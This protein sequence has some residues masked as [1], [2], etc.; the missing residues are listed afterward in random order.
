MPRALIGVHGLSVCLMMT[1]AVSGCGSSS[2]GPR[3]DGSIQNLADMHQAIGKF[4][5]QHQHLPPQTAEGDQIGQSWMTDLLPYIG[6]SSLSASIDRTQAWNSEANMAPFST[7]VAMFHSP[8]ITPAAI[9]GYSAAHYAGNVHVLKPTGGI[10]YL[11]MT[12]GSGNLI[13]AAEVNAGFKPW[14][15]PDN[16]RDPAL[17]FGETADRFGSPYP[18]V[19]V[20][21]GDGSVRPLAKD[22]ASEI[23]HALST[24]GG[25]EDMQQLMQL[26]GRK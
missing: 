2:E 21:L 12:D 19:A 11:D 20:L 16:L 22:V 24:P 25:G 10:G 6:E 17:G 14:G 3:V 7:D 23:L 8:K 9:D 18:E 26:Y 13:F 5:D 1:F 4:A 15:S